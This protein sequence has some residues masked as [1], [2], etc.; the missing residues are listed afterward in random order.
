MERLATIYGQERA[1]LLGGVSDVLSRVRDLGELV[2][3][4]DPEWLVGFSSDGDRAASLTVRPRHPGRAHHEP[5]PLLRHCRRTGPRRRARVASSLGC[6]PSETV[7]LP[8]EAVQSAR[9]SGGPFVAGEYP[10]GAVEFVTTPGGAGRG[11][12]LELRCSY[13]EPDSPPQVFEGVVTHAGP[14]PLGGTIE[15]D[16]CAGHLAIRLRLPLTEQARDGDV[17][18]EPGPDISVNYESCLP[19]VVAEVLSTARLSRLASRVEVLADGRSLVAFAVTA[20]E[21]VDEDVDMVGVEQFAG[22]L[23]VVQRHAN[24]FFDMPREM[25]PGDRVRIRVARLLC[26]GYIAASPPVRRRTMTMSGDDSPELRAQ[27]ALQEQQIVWPGGPFSET[28]DGREL[29]VGTG[30]P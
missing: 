16:F 13:D 30:Q 22:D 4:L 7:V 6:G 28:V 11:K 29:L 12:P 1:A 10:P 17:V 24:R 8:A 14:G 20:P 9:I 19:G 27:L 2:N 21:V 26:E 15:A 23:D 5:D 18:L 25:R 3:T